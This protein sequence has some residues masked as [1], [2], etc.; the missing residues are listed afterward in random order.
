MKNDKIYAKMLSCYTIARVTD[1]LAKALELREDQKSICI[2]TANLDDFIYIAGDDT[3]KK[4]DVELVYVKSMWAGGGNATSLLQGE[5]IGILAGPDIAQVRAAAEALRDF[6]NSH[7]LYGTSCNEDDSICYLTYCI[8]S[9]GSYF[10]KAFNIPLGASLSWNGAPPVESVFATDA[11]LKASNAKLVL[12]MGPPTETNWGAALLTG[13][14]ADCV[15]ANAAWGRAV[16]Q[17]ADQH[18]CI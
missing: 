13:T 1:A 10:S 17:V 7:I 4:A 16:Q 9:V 6:E 14:Q 11:A 5:G 8:S 2:F 12:F 15:T 18:I 3:T